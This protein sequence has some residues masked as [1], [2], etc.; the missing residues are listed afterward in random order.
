MLLCCVEP[1]FLVANVAHHVVM[2][3]FLDKK[4]WYLFYSNSYDLFNFLV[5]FL[6]NLSIVTNFTDVAF[7]GQMECVMFCCKHDDADT[8]RHMSIVIADVFVDIGIVSG[9]IIF[10]LY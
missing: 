2:R 7:N 9:I 3:T 6:V 4:L 1:I 10:I 8:D 5:D